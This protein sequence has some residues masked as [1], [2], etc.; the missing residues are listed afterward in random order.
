MVKACGAIGVRQ[1]TAICRDHVGGRASGMCGIAGAVSGSPSSELG[2]V[3]LEL[4][5]ALVHRG[6]DGEGFWLG[7][8]LGGDLVDEARLS[9]PAEV[10]LGHRRLSIVDIDGGAQPMSNEDGTVWVSFNGEIYNQSE[11][12]AELEGCGHRFA[13]RADTEVLVH[14]W[15]EWGESLFGRLNGIF[16]FALIDTSRRTLLLVRDPAGVKPLY[17]GTSEGIFWW[18]SELEAAIAARVL[19]RKVSPEALK[20]FLTFR[21]V[22]SPW[23]LFESAWKVP[24]GHFARLTIGEP[25]SEP[26]FRS[27]ECVIRSTAEP[28]T[29]GEWREALVD[30]LEGAVTRQLMADV[31]VASLLS[32]GVDSSLVTHLMTEHLP[33]PPETFGIGFESDGS[34]SETVAAR[35]AADVLEVPHHSRSV[36]DAEYFGMWPIVLSEF[37]EPIANTSALLVRLICQDV[38]RSHKVV[39]SGQGADEPLGGYPRH[40]V[41]RL[42][43][44]G[45]AAPS[46]SQAGTSRLFGHDNGERLVRALRA[47][48]RVDRYIEILSVVPPTTVDLLVSGASSSALE[49]A[50]EVLTRWVDGDAPADSVNELLRVD[51]RMSLADDLLI[52]GDHCA[53]RSSV[54]L[55]VPFLDLQLLEL[56]ERMPSRYKVSRL[57]KRKWLYREAA[58][59]R[60]PS[61]LANRICVPERVKPKRGFSTPLGRW[62][63]EEVDG[64]PTRPHKWGPQLSLLPLDTSV[65]IGTALSA[66]GGGAR[67]QA[68]LYM[69]ALWA[70][71]HPEQLRAAVP[72]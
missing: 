67:Q 1:I 63:E 59:D 11:L 12:R 17:V 65:D 33:Y 8:H 32:G 2:G 72:C 5:R 7:D 36:L 21:F 48:D 41:E 66:N 16:A 46:L 51:A 40:L 56:V 15:E 35:L 34:A 71:R 38:H 14:G 43:R 13:T 58:A 22:P 31:P 4:T 27:Y 60:L 61:E 19:S 50:R 20:L 70:E 10:V 49:L 25:V 28:Q 26:R 52:V 42:Y 69:L 3:V 30:E 24:P 23:T 18:A 55:R 57:G 29:R 37:G 64:S 54:E 47:R 39:L 53:M 9:Q 62:F 44:Y 6:P 68:L 45:R